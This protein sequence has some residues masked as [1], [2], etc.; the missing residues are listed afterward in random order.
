MYCIHSPSG[1]CYSERR[2]GDS[3]W[4]SCRSECSANGNHSPYGM[5]GNRGGNSTVVW[6]L[7]IR[8]RWRPITYFYQTNCVFALSISAVSCVNAGK[9][10]LWCRPK[11]NPEGLLYVW[12]VKG[13]RQWHHFIITS[14]RIHNTVLTSQKQC[15]KVHTSNASSFMSRRIEPTAVYQ[16]LQH[17]SPQ[18]FISCEINL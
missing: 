3:A 1:V 6:H 8:R 7:P 13:K 16:T 9:G 12:G 10:V 14:V 11:Q 18:S 2:S 17:Y 4:T 5:L 15:S